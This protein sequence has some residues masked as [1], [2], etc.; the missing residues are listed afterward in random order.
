MNFIEE[1]KY[2]FKEKNNFNVLIYINLI[3]FVFVQLIKVILF[4]QG[5]AHYEF[6]QYLAVPAN[7]TNLKLYPWTTITYMFT[8]ESFLHI[9]F[10]L[11]AFYWF[12]K[13]FLQ[14]LSQR[15]MLGV[16]ILGGL[17][18]AVFYIAAF[19][20]FPVFN[21]IL[22]NSLALG[23]SASVMAVV[24]AISVLT[25]NQEIYLVFLGRVKLKYLAIVVI[26]IDILSI[27]A[28]N[29][30][31]HI[32]HLG[33]AFLGAMF[34]IFYKKHIDITKFITRFIYWIK[35]LFQAKPKRVKKAKKQK[36][37]QN[38]A[39]KNSDWEYNAKKHAQQE[40]IN[41]ILD[42]VSKSGYGSLSNKEKE[43]LFRQSKK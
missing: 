24:F 17:L 18:G 11:L 9:L 22:D 30:G 28:G 36:H 13:L 27:P 35:S 26:F 41:K 2:S 16:Y 8:H 40:E 42:K 31:G 15:Q 34:S 29:A 4:L 5:K 43:L 19:N 10:N 12:G 1:F 3:V 32:A 39:N 6:I 37:K 14:Y 7:I 33:G 21:L 38:Y 25:P 23:A 20:F